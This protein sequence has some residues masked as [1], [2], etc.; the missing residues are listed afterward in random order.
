MRELDEAGIRH[1][2]R[3]SK[4]HG[5]F[6]V[7]LAGVGLTADELVR[8]IEIVA[9]E[10]AGE[11]QVA[12]PAGFEGFEDEK[13]LVGRASDAGAT[14]MLLHPPFDWK[15]AD[16]AELEAWY[17]G[18]IEAGELGTVLWAT[19]GW[20]FRHFAPGNIPV[21][22]IDRLAD[23]K[24]VLAIKPMT[25]LDEAILFD[26]C[27]K[28]HD[29]LVMGCVNLRMFPIMSKY[30][31]AT[32]S[33]A[34]TAEALQSPEKPYIADYV[35]LLNEG[36]Y[37]AA[38]QIY[39]KLGQ[40][41]EALFAMMAPLL[42]KGVHPFTQLKYYQ[43]FVGGNGG[44]LRPPHNPIERDFKL[45]PEQRE[46]IAQAYA[47]LGIDKSGP[48]ESFVTGRGIHENGGKPADFDQGAREIY[49]E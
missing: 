3:M 20:N 21:G 11:L 30:Y 41:Y 36:N 28:V 13:G 19:D 43:W 6:S 23:H 39:H 32:W 14:H 34:W 27:E 5:F 16:E 17:R 29:R 42:P 18:M 2:V 35:R 4:R 44:L 7:F 25:T 38:L 8:M 26:L 49:V 45:T 46:K 22:V 12:Y 24:R 48:D 31:G 40:A 15:P 33:G 47:T 37:D 9:D 1:D 10:A